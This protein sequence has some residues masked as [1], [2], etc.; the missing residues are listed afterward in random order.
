MPLRDASRT[1]AVRY[2]WIW[3]LH[4][5]LSPTLQNR[6]GIPWPKWDV[7]IVLVSKDSKGKERLVEK[8]VGGVETYFSIEDSTQDKNQAQ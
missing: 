6:F 3:T 5:K 8:T 2:G 1:L 4:P 7:Q